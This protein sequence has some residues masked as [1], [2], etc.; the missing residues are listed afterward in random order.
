VVSG[1]DAG[2]GVVDFLQDAVDGVGGG[3]EIYGRAIDEELAVAAAAIVDGQGQIGGGE[4]VV[5]IDAA[6]GG[7]AG[8]GVAAIVIE[9]GDLEEIAGV[10]GAAQNDGAAA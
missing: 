4:R 9:L 7:G 1:G 6:Q 8:D 5:Q 3:V 10:G 2:G